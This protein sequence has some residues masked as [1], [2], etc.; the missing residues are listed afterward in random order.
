MELKPV[1]PFAA[2]VNCWAL[3]AAIPALPVVSETRVDFCGSAAC[4][5]TLFFRAPDVR[6]LESAYRAMAGK[7]GD[8]S[9]TQ[10]GMATPSAVE[11]ACRAGGDGKYSVGWMFSGPTKDPS[12]RPWIGHALLVGGCSAGQLYGSLSFANRDA[13]GSIAQRSRQNF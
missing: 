4:R 9:P 3:P 8:Q 10:G 11:R 7:Y 5:V 12:V 6:M 1:A 13:V 2:S